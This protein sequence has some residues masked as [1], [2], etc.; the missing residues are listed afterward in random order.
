MKFLKFFKW[1]IFALTSVVCLLPIIPGIILWDRL[2]EKIAVHF[3]V[4]NNPDNFA[5]KGFAVFAIP[6]LMV[7]LQLFCC[8]VNDINSAKHGERKKF[9]TVTK[10]IVPAIS[11]LLQGVTFAYALGVDVDVRIVAVLIVGCVLIAV[12]NY[13]P[14]FDYIKNYNVDTEKARRI[15][16]FVGFQTVIMGLLFIISVFLPPVASVICLIL[17]I[18]YAIIG[19]VYGIVVGRK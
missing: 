18:P 5:S 2:P 19:I 6:T 3:D 17:L 8:F 9:E 14:K 16:R 7:I 10:W 11:V 13:L 15:N 4:N 12:G 1:K